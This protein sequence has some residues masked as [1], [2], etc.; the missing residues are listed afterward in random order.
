MALRTEDSNLSV[1][2]S[3]S[4][5]HDDSVDTNEVKMMEESNATKSCSKKLSALP[6]CCVGKLGL[7]FRTPDNTLEPCNGQVFSRFSDFSILEQTNR[8]LTTSS[9]YMMVVIDPPLKEHTT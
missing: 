3:F 5:C 6:F 7:G 4:S 8:Q 9:A 1:K 2:I